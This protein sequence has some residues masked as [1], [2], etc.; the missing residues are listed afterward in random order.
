MLIDDELK[1]LHSLVA[2]FAAK[3]TLPMKAPASTITIV[4]PIVTLLAFARY[5]PILSTVMPF[6]IPMHMTKCD[7]IYLPFRQGILVF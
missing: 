6:H 3:I 7:F 4:A 5:V 1:T 2:F